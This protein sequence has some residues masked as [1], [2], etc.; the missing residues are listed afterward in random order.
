M[1]EDRQALITHLMA[2]IT[3]RLEAAHQ[4]SVEGQLPMREWAEHAAL[5][6]QIGAIVGDVH[7]LVRAVEALTRFDPDPVPDV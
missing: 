6:G 1:D 5:A 4:I 7:S 3:A 2:E